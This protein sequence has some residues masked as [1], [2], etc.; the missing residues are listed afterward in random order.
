M[1]PDPKKTATLIVSKMGKDGDS[2]KGVET[3]SEE[4][5][6]QED[7]GMESAMT[8]FL[9]ALNT[10]SPI[11]MHKALSSYMDQHRA[12][13]NEP[14]DPTSQDEKFTE[15]HEGEYSYPSND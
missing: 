14:L 5:M 10:K 2:S 11:G 15:E 4:S 13:V 12:R 8:D 9:D 6:Q 1:Y 7:M 3:T